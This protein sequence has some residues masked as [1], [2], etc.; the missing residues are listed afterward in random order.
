MHVDMQRLLVVEARKASF[1]W[2]LKMRP[3]HVLHRSNVSYE[4]V[5]HQKGCRS[6]KQLNVARAVSNLDT[7]SCLCRWVDTRAGLSQAA[8]ALRP[9]HLRHW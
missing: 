3:F 9:M 4:I 1:P 8:E 7:R 2:R 6:V 5:G